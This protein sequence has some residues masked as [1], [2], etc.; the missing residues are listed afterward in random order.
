MKLAKTFRNLTIGT[1]GTRPGPGAAGAEPI[2]P[3]AGKV[4][5]CVEN[6]PQS[7]GS[8]S[9]AASLDG[10]RPDLSFEVDNFDESVDD[11]REPAV[12][13][14]LPKQ[15]KKKKS[16]PRPLTQV[17]EKS[18]GG[19]QHSD[20]TDAFGQRE[21]SAKLS[22]N[23]SLSGAA[24]RRRSISDF[25][26]NSGVRINTLAAADYMI[27]S[28]DADEDFGL[29]PDPEANAPFQEE[30]GEAQPKHEKPGTRNGQKKRPNIKLAI[31]PNDSSE[32][33]SLIRPIVE[34]D[35]VFGTEMFGSDGTF[36]DGGFQITKA[37]IV[38][39]PEM[40]RVSSQGDLL[41]GVPPST[42]NIIYIKSLRDIEYVE[43]IGVGACGQV[44]LAVHRPSRSHMAVKVVNVYD[45]ELRKQLLKELAT[46]TTYLSRFL[47]RFYGAFYN[48][49]AVHVV[50]EY[51]DSGS[52]EDAVKYGGKVPEEVTKQIA[53]HCLHGLS[54][55][56][57]HNIL[58]RDFKSANILLSRRLNRSKLSDFGLVK[59]LG[60]DASKAATFVG[61]LAYMSPERLE[62]SQYTSAGDI[63]GLGISICECLLGRFPFVKPE[64]YFD[65][66]GMAL[67]GDLLG[68]ASD[69][70][71]EARDF[72]A[73]CLRVNPRERSSAEALLQH[74]FVAGSSDISEFAR[75]LDRVKAKRKKRR[76]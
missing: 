75:W 38:Q 70:S 67:Q 16:R 57:K 59:E 43:P 68:G 30:P 61:T 60:E 71:S 6:V 44:Q 50:L 39:A 13:K 58:H 8:S 14:N 54:F 7:G 1:K 76:G 26:S 47:V 56:H 64:S 46:L 4:E 23:K 53:K 42:T 69:I 10:G 52:L 18:E 33:D 28:A 48:A 74:P 34:N 32:R 27:D 65:Y 55:L 19:R 66:L 63:W 22:N 29:P 35:F 51:M 12:L 5:A 17:A 73:K 2:G 49:G 9:L 72:V 36:K 62:G 45:E 20:L 11:G 3:S 41:D 21:S 24:S 31:A 37:G 15:K 40:A 25:V